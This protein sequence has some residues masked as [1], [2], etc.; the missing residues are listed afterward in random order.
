MT[1][2]GRGHASADRGVRRRT[3]PGA[4]CTDTTQARYGHDLNRERAQLGP[5]VDVAWIRNG[6][7]WAWRGLMQAM[8]CREGGAG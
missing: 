2:A 4:V 6:A 1:G 8:A 5:H 3:R 7:V